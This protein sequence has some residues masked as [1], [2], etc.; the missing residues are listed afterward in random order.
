MGLKGIFYQDC[1]LALGAVADHLFPAVGTEFSLDNLVLDHVTALDTESIR[2]LHPGRVPVELQFRAEIVR[3]ECANRG[4][5]CSDF[6]LDVSTANEFIDSNPEPSSNIFNH[7]PGRGIEPL[8]LKVGE[9]RLFDTEGDE[10]PL[11]EL[12][13]LPK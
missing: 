12:I 5:T 7:F 8:G 4:L 2:D 1:F 3:A 11:R 6:A 13:F 10:I 9:V